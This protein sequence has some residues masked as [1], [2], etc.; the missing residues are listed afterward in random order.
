[1]VR[2]LDRGEASRMYRL[3]AALAFLGILFATPAAVASA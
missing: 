3:L 1:V 2:W